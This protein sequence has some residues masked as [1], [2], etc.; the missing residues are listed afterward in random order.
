[1]PNTE[2]LRRR[3]GR[4]QEAKDIAVDLRRIL[5]I[6]A[7]NRASDAIR[8]LEEDVKVRICA[9]M[10]AAATSPALTDAERSAEVTEHHDLIAD[11]IGGEQKLQDFVLIR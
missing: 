1:M 6:P 4:A 11:A 2:R 5:E 10:F 9:L 7:G 3:D 8:H